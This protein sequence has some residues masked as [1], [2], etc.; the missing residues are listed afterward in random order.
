MEINHP[1]RGFELKLITKSET[2]QLFLKC[3]YCYCSSKILSK[4]RRV[5]SSR[6]SLRKTREKL[7]LG[8]DPDRGWHHRHTSV[9]LFGRSPW[10]NGHRR[11]HTI[12]LLLSPWIHGLRPRKLYTSVAG[13][14]APVWVLTQ[15]PL[16]P[17]FR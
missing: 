14:P 1:S 17:S 8:R 5:K 16:V 9:K 13:T 12:V 3:C 4:S 15:R 6:Y 10:L 2:D 11:Q 7:P